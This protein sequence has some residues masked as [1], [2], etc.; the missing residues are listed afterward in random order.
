MCVYINISI[1][2]YIYTYIF[3]YVHLFIYIVIQHDC[4]ISV[5]PLIDSSMHLDHRPCQEHGRERDRPWS[6]ACKHWCGKPIRDVVDLDCFPNGKPQAL[7]ILRVNIYQGEHK[8]AYDLIAQAWQHFASG[9]SMSLS[10]VHHSLL[11]R[12][13]SNSNHNSWLLSQFQPSLWVVKQDLEIDYWTNF[14][15]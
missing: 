8:F 11:K 4:T 13:G 5:T 2:I 3:R 9:F 6:I 1:H 7:N 14:W 12:G 10:R 15:I